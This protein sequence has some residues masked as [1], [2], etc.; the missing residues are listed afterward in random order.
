M[1]WGCCPSPC[2]AQDHCCPSNSF[3]SPRH[4]Q[5]GDQTLYL[6]HPAHQ[7]RSLEPHTHFFSTAISFSKL[8][9]LLRGDFLMHFRA[10]SLPVLF[11][12]TRKTSEK[13]PLQR[14]GE[15]AFQRG[16]RNTRGKQRDGNFTWM[17]ILKL[18]LSW[19][20]PR[21]RMF[22]ARFNVNRTPQDVQ[23]KVLQC[24]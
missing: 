4:H 3:W 13:A 23:G 12:F 11:C 9:S 5:R 22:K 1:F 15:A 21:L 8:L 14:G 17:L 24:K 19:S 6:K 7:E 2:M 20:S 16:L 18:D 10:K